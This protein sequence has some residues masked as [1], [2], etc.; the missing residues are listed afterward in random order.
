MSLSD[1]P[2]PGQGFQQDYLPQP[3]P[4]GLL[5]LWYLEPSPLGFFPAVVF[6]GGQAGEI[7]ILPCGLRSY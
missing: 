5:L 1:R 6:P 3:S 2:W 7:G 4:L